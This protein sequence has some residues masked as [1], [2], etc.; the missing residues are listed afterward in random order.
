[1]LDNLMSLK[2]LKNMLLNDLNHHSLRLHQFIYHGYARID[3]PDLLML[4]HK[5]TL[6][7]S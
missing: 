7:L 3:I 6:N 4:R 1:M 5:I 2:N